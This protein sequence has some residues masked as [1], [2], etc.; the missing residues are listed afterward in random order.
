MAYVIK[1]SKHTRVLQRD[2]IRVEIRY[3]IIVGR[4]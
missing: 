1:T 4:E 2:P 3:H